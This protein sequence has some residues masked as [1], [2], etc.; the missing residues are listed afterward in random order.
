MPTIAITAITSQLGHRAAEVLLERG[1]A[2]SDIVG[3]TRDASR[4]TDLAERGVQIREADYLDPASWT[5]ALAGVDRV[6]LVSSGDAAG[7]RGAQHRAVIDAAKAAGVSLIAYTSI[8]N[9]GTTQ[10]LLA[11][12]HKETEQALAEAGVPYVLLR[13]GW[14]TENYLMGV[15]AVIE[16]GLAGSAG[17][18]RVQVAA[19]ADYAEA[20][21]IV[22]SSD[23]DQAGKVY[24]F[25][26]DTPLNHHELAAIIGEAAGKEVAYADLPVEAYTQI[27]VG[28]GLPEGFATVLADSSVGIGRGELVTDSG[29]LSGILGRPTTPAADTIT[30]AV[31]GVTA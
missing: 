26:G 22:I 16:H 2:P 28:A 12:A 27:L 30:K 13:N 19:R 10:M 15:E 9:A 18:G 25:A 1:V 11:G 7:D 29:D 8:L 23:E 6:L 20:A 5:S 24:E 3:T 31:Q 14:Y 17:E 21:A 4:A